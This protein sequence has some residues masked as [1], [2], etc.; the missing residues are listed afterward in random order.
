MKN[1]MYNY[2]ICCTLIVTCL[3]IVSGCTNVEGQDKPAFVPEVRPGVL[4]GYLTVKDL[5][6]SS[7]LLPPPPAPGSAAFGLDEEVSR[8]NLALQGTLRWKL[9][10]MDA[11]LTF[12]HAADTFSCAL[13]APINK[14]DTPRLYK[15]MR[16]ILID[17]D[18]STRS[19]KEKYKRVRPFTVNKKPICTPD[20]EEGLRKNGS[21]PSGHTTIGWA[22]AL[23]LTEIDPDHADA[24]LARGRTF[25]ESRLV[26]N[27]HWQS[28]VT[29]GYFMGAAVVARL[30][31]DP[32]FRAD[33][34]AAGKE[35]KAARARGL[36]PTRDCRAEAE[37]LGR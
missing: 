23:A 31:G 24:I 7:A 17:A 35:L 12:P 32:S 34:E 18:H 37:A 4:K 1:S 27:V 6:D 14:Q 5:P 29:E 10:I 3:V 25:G 26:C 28:D 2:A 22:W 11:D 8:K 19:A 36:K 33:A 13:N 30:H 21:Y 9:A 15:L 20:D 16:R